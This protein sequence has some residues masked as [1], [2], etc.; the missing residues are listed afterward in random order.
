MSNKNGLESNYRSFVASIILQA[1][2]DLFT[3][4]RAIEKGKTRANKIADVLTNRKR[5]YKLF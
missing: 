4:R 1:A 2:N 3:C 5:M